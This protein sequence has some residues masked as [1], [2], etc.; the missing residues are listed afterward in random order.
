ASMVEALGVSLPGNAAIP[1]VDAR[2][3][4]LAQL[5]GR[6]IVEMVHEDLRLSRVLTPAAFENAIRVNAAIG[7]STNA[8]IHLLAIA[9]RLGVPLTLEDFDR[10]GSQLPCLV[11]LQPSGRFL[12]EDFFYAGGLPA[13]MKEIGQHL[14]LDALTV[15]GRTLGENIE[16]AACYNRE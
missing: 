5:T 11:D 6:R 1:A 13:V 12:M 10:I 14:A 9:G 7:G 15:N 16:E 8:V 3:H 2:R 4:R